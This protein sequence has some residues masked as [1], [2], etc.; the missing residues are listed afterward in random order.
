MTEK[1]KLRVLIVDDETHIRTL[2]KTVM[3]SMDALVIGE[4]KNGEEAV[5]IFKDKKPDIVMLDI[6]MPVKDGT[7]ALKEIMSEFPDAFVVMMTSVSDMETVAKCI[8]LGASHYIRKDTPIQEI[9]KM[10]K[11]AWDEY[12]KSKGESNA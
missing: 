9:K 11:E 5:A 3:S 8:D 12:K 10:V 7:E 4:A 1:N 2:F 6:N